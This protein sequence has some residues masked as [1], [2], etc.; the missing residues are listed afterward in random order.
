[1]NYLPRVVDG[2][3][4]A[5]L[6]SAGAVLIEGPKA[7]GKTRTAEQQARSAVYLDRD[8]ASLLALQI[9]PTLVLAGD[10]PQLV[11][12]WQLDGT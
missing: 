11:D 5:R 12:E 6:G 4:T 2:L 3:L 9:D 1:M 8:D 10:P 7:C